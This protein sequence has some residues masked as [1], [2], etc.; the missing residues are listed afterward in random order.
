META[1]LDL[2][3][4]VRANIFLQRLAFL[5]ERI[6]PAAGWKECDE[7]RADVKHLSDRLSETTACLCVLRYLAHVV[8]PVIEEW[9]GQGETRSRKMWAAVGSFTSMI[10]EGLMVAVKSQFVGVSCCLSCTSVKNE[11]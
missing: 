6:G 7:Y 9:K 3:G 8:E 5:L 4:A 1:S 2:L 11:G 10:K